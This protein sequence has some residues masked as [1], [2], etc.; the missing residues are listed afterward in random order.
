MTAKQLKTMPYVAAHAYVLRARHPM[1][2][3]YSPYKG[4]PPVL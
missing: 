3:Q 1:G 2:P 4:V